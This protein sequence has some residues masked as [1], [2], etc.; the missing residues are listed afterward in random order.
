MSTIIFRKIFPLVVLNVPTFSGP[1]SWQS[2]DVVQGLISWP[3][4]A[5]PLRAIESF[6]VQ[7]DGSHFVVH[8]KDKDGIS[9]TF[10]MTGLS[11]KNA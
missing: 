2:H 9:E 1:L 11:P 8:L 10:E 3:L 6:L 5:H 7:P 4:P